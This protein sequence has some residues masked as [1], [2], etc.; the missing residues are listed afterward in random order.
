M[1]ALWLNT[2]PGTKNASAGNRTRVTSMATMYSTTR[3]LML[4]DKF[5]P[6][7]HMFLVLTHPGPPA[8]VSL[9]N[10]ARARTRPGQ[11]PMVLPGT[12]S[13]LLCRKATEGRCTCFWGKNSQAE[14]AHY[15][16]KCLLHTVN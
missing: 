14:C 2:F 6:A 8:G 16:E 7:S 3:P 9:A 10:V 1:F 11:V 13:Q 12:Q 5:G 15:V 4:L